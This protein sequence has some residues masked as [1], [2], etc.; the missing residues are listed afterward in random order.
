MT[1]ARIIID[2]ADAS[3]VEFPGGDTL[4]LATGSFVRD[5]DHAVLPEAPEVGHAT[6]TAADTQLRRLLTLAGGISIT[7][8][9]SR[10][11]QAEAFAKLHD[12]RCFALH[13]QMRGGKTKVA[14][15]I[16]CSHHANGHIDH[17]LWCCPLSVVA[18][19][20]Q[21][22][23]RWRTTDVPVDFAPLETISQ[24]GHER[25]ATLTAGMTDKSALIIDESHMV[26]NGLTCRHK[27]LR[28]LCNKAVVRGLLTGT[29]ITNNVQDIYDQMRLL[30]WRI[31]GYTS[32]W[33][34]CDAHLVMSDKYPGL[35]RATRNLDVLQQR[36]APY[37]YEWS[38][39][40]DSQRK[41]TTRWLTMSDAQQEWYADIKRVVIDRLQQMAEREHDIYLLFTALS[42]VLSGYLSPRLLTAVYQRRRERPAIFDTPKYREALDW[43]AE[44]EGHALVWCARRHEIDTLAAALPEAVVIHG[45]IA[46]DERHTRIARFRERGGVLL[47]MMQVARRGIELYECDDVLYYSQTFDYEARA[48]SEMRTLLPTPES[49]CRYTDLIIGN[50]LDE[51]MRD[52]VDSKESIAQ[53][54]ARL[55]RNDKE[56]ALTELEQ[57]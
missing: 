5:G 9:P 12:L 29:P 54:F 3:L 13:M 28:P 49:H 40:Y 31:L 46:P 19:A 56:R 33:R 50:S 11:H 17:V 18:T 39:D 26:K 25:L 42:S 52:A 20:K 6:T 2:T 51:R 27:R 38:H 47:A 45:D 14:I 1:R 44:Q 48:Q 23:Q 53:R 15:D 55:F 34:F 35:I 7:P 57:L 21:Q 10:P 8:K 37:V 36:M 24:C 22:W 32:Y 30:D 16:L 4:W 43:I 41:Y